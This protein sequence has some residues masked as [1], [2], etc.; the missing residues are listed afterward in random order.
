MPSRS[1]VRIGV[2]RPAQLKPAKQCNQ[3]HHWRFGSCNIGHVPRFYL[4]E[5]FKRRC[6]DYLQ[7]GTQE[8]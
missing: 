7:V 8:S 2:Y 4:G 5:G 6:E 1:G 3:C